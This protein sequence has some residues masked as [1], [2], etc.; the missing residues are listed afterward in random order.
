[1]AKKQEQSLQDEQDEDSATI[2]AQTLALMELPIR[3]R[4]ETDDPPMA[5]TKTKTKKGDKKKVQKDWEKYFGTND[6]NLERW[7]Q[8]GRDLDIPEERLTSKTQ[9]RKVS[10]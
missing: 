5:K 2:P 10:G 6:N 3:V 9:I 1:M 7:Q 4:N 8:L